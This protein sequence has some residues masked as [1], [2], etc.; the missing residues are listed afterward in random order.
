MIRNHLIAAAL[1]ASTAVACQPKPPEP[2]VIAAPA[3][4]GTFSCNLGPSRITLTDGPDQMN[5]DRDGARMTL[6]RDQTLSDDHFHVATVTSESGRTLSVVLESNGHAT[7]TMIGGFD[8]PRQA[9]A[10]CER[11]D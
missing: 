3:S 2:Q 11:I 10:D 5:F 4:F 7:V 6:D 8:A 9:E 1:V